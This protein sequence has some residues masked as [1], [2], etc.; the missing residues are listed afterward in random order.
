MTILGTSL[1]TSRMAEVVSSTALASTCHP[2]PTASTAATLVAWARGPASA[3]PFGP[4]ENA[5]TTT[6]EFTRDIASTGMRC[7]T[8]VVHSVL[9]ISL[10]MPPAHLS[11]LAQVA[12]FNASYAKQ[13]PGR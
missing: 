4:T 3:S 7:R 6:S 11:N 13:F 1:R 5:P 12:D 8:V 9:W 10:T 2:T